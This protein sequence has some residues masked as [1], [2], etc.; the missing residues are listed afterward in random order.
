[1]VDQ[2]SLDKLGTAADGYDA[3][4]KTCNIYANVHYRVIYAETGAEQYL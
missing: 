2:D 4:T 3:N 1:M